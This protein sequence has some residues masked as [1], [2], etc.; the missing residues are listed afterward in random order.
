MIL[1][2]IGE[3]EAH[4]VFVPCEP[5]GK[6]TADDIGREPIMFA[7]WPDGIGHYTTLVSFESG[8]QDFLPRPQASKSEKQQVFK[9]NAICRLQGEDKAA[10]TY[11][12]DATEG[13]SNDDA[14]IIDSKAGAAMECACC[15]QTKTLDRGIGPSA[16]AFAVAAH[17]DFEK[18]L[19]MNGIEL[20]A[21]EHYLRAC[22]SCSRT[23]SQAVKNAKNA[24]PTC[25]P[26]VFEEGQRRHP[27]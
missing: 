18:Q 2:I 12:T 25:E 23:A 6:E 24:H 26:A 17:R 11:S 16:L 7:Y 14:K 15:G 27:T 5:L 1:F 19:T 21:S 10:G 4:D 9:A 3:D 22:Q 8:L 20:S 13:R